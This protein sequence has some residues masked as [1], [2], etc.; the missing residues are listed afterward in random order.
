MWGAA[1]QT[2]NAKVVGVTDGGRPLKV[3]VPVFNIAFA[4]QSRPIAAVNNTVSV[5]LQ[6]NTNLAHAESS[7]VVIRGFHNAIAPAQISLAPLPY[8]APTD[9]PWKRAAAARAAYESN[10]QGPCVTGEG[11]ALENTPCRFPFS[12]NGSTYSSC[13]EEVPGERGFFWC[14]TTT[15]YT[16][17]WGKC[18]CD[19]S[20]FGVGGQGGTASWSEGDLTL[21]LMTGSVMRAQQTYQFLFDVLNPAAEQPAPALSVEANGTALYRRAAVSRPHL[22]VVGVA[23]GSD[24]LLVEEPEFV[25]RKIAQ[26]I[27]MSRFKN[28]LTVTIMSNV[29]LRHGDA[30]VVTIAGL[31]GAQGPNTISLSSPEGGNQGNQLFSDGGQRNSTAAYANGVVRLY[32]YHNQTL[33]AHLAYIISFELT[34]PDGERL[35]GPVVLVSAT[36]TAEM[37]AAA[38]AVPNDRLYGVPNGTNPL[39]RANPN[40]DTRDIFQSLPIADLINTITVSL[41]PSI[42]LGF[43]DGSSITITG[44]LNGINPAGGGLR[45]LQL[46][47]EAALHFAAFANGTRSGLMMGARR[48]SGVRNDL[49][50][51]CRLVSGRPGF[52]D[53]KDNV[54][55]MYLAVNR[56]LVKGQ[57]YTFGFNLTNPRL[58]QPFGD[59]RVSAFS[60]TGS[61][62]AI[63][64]QVGVLPWCARAFYR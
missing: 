61:R 29:D 31:E 46:H 4:R 3:V 49:L 23:N 55:T 16:G 28:T 6:S 48:W 41:S 56:T 43:T 59:V 17:L 9:L 21:T 2:P 57:R 52:V 60:T 11:T 7:S 33:R 40:F 53:Y 39:V 18:I 12:F 14:S 63:A 5:I 10:Y 34:N 37:E 36:G 20:I 44:L 27:P 50:T 35:V 42:N 54:L 51:I 15:N 24:P 47:G 32:L 25:V 19:A 8:R 45:L 1:A 30:S 38:M 62:A 13:V 22:P 58:D 26:S 64:P